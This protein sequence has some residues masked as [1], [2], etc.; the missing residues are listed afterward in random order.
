METFLRGNRDKLADKKALWIDI[1]QLV[2]RQTRPDSTVT[3]ALFEGRVEM[4]GR[5]HNTTFIE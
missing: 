3:T 2:D 4:F 5:L 1:I